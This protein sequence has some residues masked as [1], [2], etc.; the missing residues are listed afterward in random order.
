MRKS[1][2]RDVIHESRYCGVICVKQLSAV[3]QVYL[4]RYSRR[5]LDGTVSQQLPWKLLALIKISKCLLQVFRLTAKQSP[6]ST[7]PQRPRMKTTKR[8]RWYALFVRTNL[9]HLHAHAS[10]KSLGPSATE[11]WPAKKQTA[12]EEDLLPVIPVILR[13]PTSLK[14][15]RIALRSYAPARLSSFIFHAIS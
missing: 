7:W 13:Q 1:N 15:M 14:A 9:D 11:I 12:E 4:K 3:H 10:Q 2:L 6:R 5:H 8:K